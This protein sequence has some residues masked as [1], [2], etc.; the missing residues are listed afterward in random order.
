MQAALPAVFGPTKPKAVDL[1]GRVALV[2][3]GA[4]GIGYEIS[5]FLATNGAR[6]IMVNRKEEQGQE[7]I[8]KIKK[9]SDG[10]AQIEWLPCDLGS[11]SEI[12]E[13]FSDIREREKR[14]DILVLNAGINSNAYG[15]DADGIDR[16]FGVNWLGNFYA[17]N[18]LWPLLKTTSKLPGVPAPRIVIES[19]EMHRAAPKVVHFGSISE[20]NNPDMSPV[21]LYGR[22]KLALILGTKYLVE[23]IIKPQKENIYA[24]AV[25]PGVVNTDM[26]EQWKDTYPG[27]T[28]QAL[29]Q[30]NY[31]FGR[32]PEQGSY[33]GIYAATS[34]EIEEKDWNGAYL[35][36]PA[37]L[38]GE[39]AQAQDMQ[40]ASSLWNLSQQLIKE[41]RGPESM[42]S[43]TD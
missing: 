29:T 30:L 22:T 43:W 23:K 19:S 38:G 42:M 8:E 17:L 18:Q 9:E 25:H 3:G 7:A 13:T 28:G 20:I 35:S 2:T 11:L 31:L 41:R 12:Q 4:L 36:D 33:S 15:E 5:R 21:Q 14:L 16:H 39:T 32:S 6:V 27:L 40:L 1:S 26:Q 37:K 34:P 10:K 24:V